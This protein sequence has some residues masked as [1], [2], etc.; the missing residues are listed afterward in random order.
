MVQESARLSL[1]IELIGLGQMA[2]QA[3]AAARAQ[4]QGQPDD[5]R[6]QAAE[7]YEGQSRPPS[8]ATRAPATPGG[9]DPVKGAPA[10]RPAR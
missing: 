5:S 1:S 9:W 2:A 7:A 4:A 3:Q 10:S 6:K 8:Y